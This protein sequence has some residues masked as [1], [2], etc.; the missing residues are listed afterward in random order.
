MRMT[1]LAAAVLAC[2]AAGGA[3]AAAPDS[4]NMLNGNTGSYN[5]WDETYTGAGCVTCDNS[6][7]TGGKGDLTDGTIAND[8][9]FVTE[10]PPGNGP[11][12]GWTLDPVI[13]FHWNAS[14][15]VNSVTFYLDD[16]NGAGGVS[17]P[18]GI[19]VNG[20]L[21]V[22]PEPAGSAPF[23][24]TAGS[25]GFTGTDLQVQLLRK[26]SWVFLSEVEFNGQSNA[27]PE[28]ETYAL[29]LAG[30]GVMATVARRR[31]AK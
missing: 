18:S 22:V 9:W 7:L 5:Y 25:V 6:S 1:Q 23:S 12:V 24:F 8:N 15:V 28:P 4:Y 29:M 19:I 27:I 26:N 31:K 30:L 3:S 10:A 13:T 14:T 20:N 16:S 21:Y 17:A 11:Y 2:V